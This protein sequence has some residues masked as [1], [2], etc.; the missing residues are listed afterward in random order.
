MTT[1]WRLGR[2]WTLATGVAAATSP[3]KILS[4]QVMLRPSVACYVQFA[5]ADS[6]TSA[7][8]TSTTP[9]LNF[10]MQANEE[11]IFQVENLKYVSAIRV[12]ADG[13]LQITELN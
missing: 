9:S 10:L 1:I 4:T 3:T 5:L 2:S 6:G 7:A 13:V 12:S 11:R 8:A